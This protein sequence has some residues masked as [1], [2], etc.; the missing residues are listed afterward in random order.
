MRIVHLADTHLGFRQFPGCLDPDRGL[1]QRECD[2]YDAWHRAIDVAIERDVD[3]VV[4]AGDLFDSPRPTMRAVSEALDGLGRLRD[5]GIPVVA[6]AGN[7]STPRYRSAGSVFQVLQRFGVHAA[8]DAPER[9]DIGGV[10]FCAVP[11][12]ADAQKLRATVEGLEPDPDAD[13][14]VLILHTG[15]EA[16]PRSSYG[17]VNAVELGQDVLAGVAFDYIAL[18]HLHR[19][20]APQ[21]NAIYPG[22]LERLDFADLEGEKAVLEIDLAAGAGADGFVT[23]HP[24]HTRP[25]V[26]VVVECADCDPDEVL[27]RLRAKIA[28]R[29]LDGAVVRVRFNELQRDVFHALD[30]VQIDALFSTC[31]HHVV[32]VG[33]GGLLSAGGDEDGQDLSFGSFARERVPNGLDAERIIAIA[34]EFLDDALTEEHEQGAAA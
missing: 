5:A 1:N 12:E 18:G 34:R 33:S 22:S 19:F 8:W 31:L 7:H 20:Q 28:G 26:D 14:N 24:I 17:E 10:A 15:L 21:I 9:F 6:I 2:V 32:Q 13:A 29:Q 25:V 16:V 23:R 30:A 27:T 11:H 3:A 4:H